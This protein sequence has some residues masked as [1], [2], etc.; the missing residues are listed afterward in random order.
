[1]SSLCAKFQPSSI[2]PSDRFWWGVVLLV[3]ILLVTGV[4]QSQVLRL[5]LE[6]DNSRWQ[7]TLQKLAVWVTKWRRNPV[8]IFQQFKG[9]NGIGLNTR[10]N[11]D[12][13]IRT[14]SWYKWLTDTVRLILQIYFNICLMSNGRR[15]R[16]VPHY[17]L[18]KR[19][20]S[21]L[22]RF[23]GAAAAVSWTSNRIWY[24]SRRV[25]DMI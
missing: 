18:K 23:K 14:W 7:F 2:P 11:Q 9:S 4:K 13:C 3:L 19:L 6:F 1:M 25:D 21:L 16:A 22:L 20:T 17:R 8:N 12:I 24:F 10:S 15:I 5:S